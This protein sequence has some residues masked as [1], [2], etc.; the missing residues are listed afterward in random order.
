LLLLPSCLFSVSLRKT[1]EDYPLPLIN[2]KNSL[3]NI[4]DKDNFFSYIIGMLEMII[5][6]LAFCI[7]LVAL[8]GF[9]WENK[10]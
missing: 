2:N 6:L 4:L 3:K 9:I 1:V 5:I 10:R 7:P 8:I